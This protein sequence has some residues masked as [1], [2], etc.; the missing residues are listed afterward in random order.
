MKKT[1]LCTILLLFAHSPA[2]AQE[3]E[4]KKYEIDARVL[5]EEFKV[6]V[7]ARL[8]MVNLSSPDLA[9]KIL[10]A[11]ES[12]PRLSFFLNLNAKVESMKF[13]AADV[14]VSTSE[15]QRNKLQRVFTQL[16]TTMASTREFDI[17]LAY[18]INTTERNA[19]VHVSRDEVFLLPASF[20]VPVVHTPYADHG[21]DT[22]PLSIKVEVPAGLK[23]VSSGIRK[24]ENSFEQT[25]ATQPFFFAGDYEVITRGGSAHPVEVYYPRG[26]SEIGKQQ[27]DRLA[28][29]AERII[30]FYVRYF[31][32]PSLAP[33]RLIATQA[34]QLTTATTDSFSS[35]RE[36]SLSTVGA[37]TIDDNLFRRD[38]L[39]LGTIELLAGAAAR[40]W[41]DGQV[42]LRG[43]GTGVLR[44][45]LPI[46]L[47]AQ[48]LGERFGDAQRTEAF[49]RYRRS[50]ATI[51]RDDA[52]L[53]MQSPLDRN[54]IT[55][56][57]NKGALV[58]RLMEK[59][60]GQQIFDKVIRVSLSR[61]TTD[62]LSLSAWRS[63]LCNLSRCVN[64][65]TTFQ[66]NGADRKI[67]DEIFSNW[68]DGIA[69][70]A[71]GTLTNVLPDIAVGQP[72]PTATNIESTV[73]N[74]GTGD[75]TVEIVA[76]T[77]KGE[78]LKQY[79]TVKA[80]E[81]SAAVFPS[82]TKIA[83]IEADPNKLFL[84]SDYT[85][86]TFPRK[87]TESESF[88]QANLAYSK[89]D[90]TTA[91]TKGREALRANTDSPTLQ[92]LLGRALLAQNKQQEAA[93]IFGAALKI[94]PLPIVAYGWAHQGLGEI[95]LQQNR[96]ADAVRHFRFAAAADLDAAATITARDGMLKADR[97]ANAIKIPEDIRAFFQKFDAAVLQS[98]ADVVNPFLE[99]G[100]L[101]N[102][103]KLLVVRKPSVWVTELLRADVWDAT[104]TA[105]DVN[106]KIKIE[107]KDY[108]GRAVYVISR[109]TGGKL[110]LSEVPVFD[111]K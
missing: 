101:R 3:F 28:V 86:D 24:N 14:P 100:S 40:A 29:E 48:Y 108:S 104:R 41:I 60:I 10:L 11:G 88:G 105:L 8:R 50:Y 38:T 111:V 109:S 71:S 12:R 52:P 77:D 99:L 59:Q 1:F 110:V 36:V 21:A 58:W 103:G 30:A 26:T 23:V 31:G 89:N 107:N 84:Q 44:D 66:A 16:T 62:V 78:K 65:K 87:P 92:A 19:A 17:E 102:F 47:T 54:Y 91:E 18:S 63:P 67:V 76:T 81:Y 32:V 5:P 39:D 106:L 20:W 7:Q 27:A 82:G 97:A 9:D 22:A 70:D 96:P 55:S 69:I 98:T 33:F 56:V 46:Y 37:V 42:L 45:A 34:R 72:Q 49:D 73:A 74:F 13:N 83:S 75:L 53:L 95:A 61:T 25:L 80:G 4:I 43:R 90:F 6:A 2:L 64:L 79:V 57:Y 51:A 68:I 15:D 93:N 85:N 94:E 35:A